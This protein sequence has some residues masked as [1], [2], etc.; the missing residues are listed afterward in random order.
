V[1]GA[2]RLE[3]RIG[4]SWLMAGGGVSDRGSVRL[5]K[6][7]V[8]W[9]IGLS[10]GAS[11]IKRGTNKKDLRNR[12]LSNVVPAQVLCHTPRTASMIT[13]FPS[14]SS[15]SSFH[16]EVLFVPFELLHNSTSHAH[17]YLLPFLFPR[18]VFEEYLEM[19]LPFDNRTW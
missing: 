19:T 3:F 4:R 14:P 8:R 18:S 2:Q 12:T 17:P 7:C 10:L 1:P 5:P 9:V 11:Y 15:S 16:T 13:S 6:G